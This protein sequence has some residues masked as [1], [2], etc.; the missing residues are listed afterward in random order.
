MPLGRLDGTVSVGSE[1]NAQLPRPTSGV[2]QLIA[3]FAAKGLTQQDMVVLS[4]KTRKL[5]ADV[6]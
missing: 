6:F 1:A 3:A 4:G 2:D 5:F